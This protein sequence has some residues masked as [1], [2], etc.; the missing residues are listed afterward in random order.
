[1]L[2]ELI[3][4]FGYDS[5]AVLG[6]SMGSYMSAQAAILE[7]ARVARLVLVVSKAHGRTSSTAAYAA[8]NGFDLNAATQE[9]ILAFMTGALWSPFTSQSRRD[10]ILAAQ[11]RRQVV[12]LTP[13]DRAAIDQSLRDFDLRPGLAEITAPALVIS[14]R[15]DGLNPPE[16]GEELARAIPNSRFE[17]FER[18]GHMLP[19]EE[20]SRL[21][22]EVEDFLSGWRMPPP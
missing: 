20:M 10:D 18:S 5:A 11:T 17:V 16:A 15:A 12:T 6:I 8:K 1:M 19:F 7:P 4:G 22:E 2:D 9:E 13:A 14:G 3:A 21:V